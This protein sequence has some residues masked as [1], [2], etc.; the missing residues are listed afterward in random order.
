MLGYYTGMSSNVRAKIIAAGLATAAAVM[1]PA[2]APNVVNGAAK[3]S[4]STPATTA[5]TS[6]APTTVTTPVVPSS[7]EEKT[8]AIPSRY[9]SMV[10]SIK[11][12]TK[13]VREFLRANG[14][15]V[16]DVVV[17]G[18]LKPGDIETCT[19]DITTQT[20]AWACSEN[21]PREIVMY[22]PNLYDQV[23]TPAGSVG[24][25]TVVAHEFGHIALPMMGTNP[26]GRK[27]E[28]RA[29]CV[30]GAFLAW[31]SDHG[32]PTKNQVHSALV[33][34]HPDT[35]GVSAN[36]LAMESGMANGLRSC[37][38]YDDGYNR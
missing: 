25:A 5:V 19:T 1:L 35:T 26:G 36:R 12:S 11:A 14:L 7:K 32:G 18:A 15:D 33:K 23:Y 16:D 6:A 21:T 31:Y 10:D 29:D 3:S 20:K 34:M 8:P 2:C 27:E 30:A 17:H 22:V 13:G 9:R 37:V 24:I 4:T 38:T 28:R